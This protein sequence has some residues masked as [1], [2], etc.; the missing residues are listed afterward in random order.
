MLTANWNAQAQGQT[1]AQTRAQALTF[2]C[3]DSAE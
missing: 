3:M 1:P 2:V